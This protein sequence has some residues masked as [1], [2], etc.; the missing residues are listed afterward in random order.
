MWSRK[1][2]GVIVRV[3][4]GNVLDDEGVLE[5]GPAP[6]AFDGMFELGHSK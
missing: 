6:A 4:S 3:D 2:F 5:F 1:G